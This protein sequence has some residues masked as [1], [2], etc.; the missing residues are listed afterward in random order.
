MTSIRVYQLVANDDGKETTLTATTE[1]TQAV[2]AISLAIAR[3]G[4]GLDDLQV[5]VWSCGNAISRTPASS[6]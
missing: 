2:A 4:W 5:V 3:Q 6:I 1:H